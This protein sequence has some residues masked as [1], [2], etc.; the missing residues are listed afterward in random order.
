MALEQQLIVINL[1][2]RAPGAND[3]GS[4]IGSLVGISR[5]IKEQN[6]TFSNNIELVAFC[7]EEQGLIGSSYYAR[8]ILLS[9]LFP[10]T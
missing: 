8:M 4:G 3:D 10:Q 7:A 5:V 6:I 9:F 1:S 2:V